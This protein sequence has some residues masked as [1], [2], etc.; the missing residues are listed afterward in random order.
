MPR[1]SSALSLLL[2]LFTAGL[3]SR[4]GAQGFEN[5]RVQTHQVAPGVYMLTG[6][7]G[8]IGVSV[9]KDGVFL[10][11]DQF[12]EI[13]PK[14][15]AAIAKLS[16][17][18]IRFVLNT[19]WHRD[20]TGGNEN[21]ARAGSLVLAHDNVRKRMSVEQFNK[22]SGRRTPASAKG[23]LPVV[24]FNDTLTFHLNDL[25]VHAF[26]VESG[27]T[28]GDAIVHFR[29]INVIHM[30]DIHFNGR[31]P[32]IDLASG[33]SV[34]G[35]IA[36]VERAL[37]LMDRKTRVIPGHGPLSNH[38]EL[39]VYHGMLVTLRQRVRDAIARG[40]TLEQVLAARPTAEFDAGWGGGFVSFE[41]FTRILYQDL[42]RRD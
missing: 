14:I 42:S 27:H 24:T 17:Q 6:R 2:V 13:T 25:E 19:H 33:G 10:I 1:A 21:L 36:A 23:A 34:D 31:Y 4:P 15:R 18:P 7:G 5:V 32:F 30:G 22:L 41:R 26:H 39:R 12:G 20:H 29:N 28:D 9:G 40:Q 35:T 16:D 38:A 11:D 8:N 3:A 37:S